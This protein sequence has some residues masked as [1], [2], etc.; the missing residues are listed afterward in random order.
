MRYD[1]TDFAW[2]VIQPLLPDKSRGGR[3][4][5]DPVCWPPSHVRRYYARFTYQ[6]GRWP[7][8]RGVVAKVARHPGLPDRTNQF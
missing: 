4:V 6:T 8:A 5:D 7:K 3:R 1:L 2:S